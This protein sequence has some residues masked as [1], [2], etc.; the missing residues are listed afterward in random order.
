MAVL[1]PAAIRHRGRRHNGH[2]GRNGHNSHV[3]TSADIRPCRRMLL[4]KAV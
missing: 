4:R 3:A 2:D 1:V